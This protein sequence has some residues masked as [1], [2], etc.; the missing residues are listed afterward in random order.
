MIYTVIISRFAGACKA[1]LKEVERILAEAGLDDDEMRQGA[2]AGA[3]GPRDKVEL[4]ADMI[5]ARP[6]F[7]SS[8]LPYISEE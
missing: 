1:V 6:P 2:A 5:L 7:V 4:G 8:K 3:G